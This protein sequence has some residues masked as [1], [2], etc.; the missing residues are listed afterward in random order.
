MQLQV[1][2]QHPKPTK[3]PE[4][5]ADTGRWMPAADLV[6]LIHRAE[7]QSQAQMQQQGITVETSRD[8]HDAALAAMAIC[9]RDNVD[10]ANRVCL[11]CNSGAIGDEKHMIFERTA[12]APLRQRHVDLFTPRTDTMRS[13]FAQQDHPGVLNY[14]IDCLNFMNV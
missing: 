9:C 2:D 5:L 3:E 8:I 13:F 7:Q 6:H 12:L 14:D 10:K 11:A 1:A 4:G